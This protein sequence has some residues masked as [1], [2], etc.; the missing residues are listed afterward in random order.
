MEMAGG[1]GGVEGGVGP[2]PLAYHTLSTL[3]PTI[4]AAGCAGS[5]TK[6]SCPASSPRAIDASSTLSLFTIVCESALYVHAPKDC[7][8][9]NRTNEAGSPLAGMLPLAISNASWVTA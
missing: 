8:A 6:T 7:M 3:E 1:G 2:S 9:R 5:S 4:A